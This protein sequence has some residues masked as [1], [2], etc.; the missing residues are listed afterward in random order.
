[1][2][3]IRNYTDSSSGLTAST[4]MGF[5]DD[6]LERLCVKKW[7]KCLLFSSLTHPSSLRELQAR[8]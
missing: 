5:Y 8:R 1:M 2:N 4:A 3:N 7:L 6:F